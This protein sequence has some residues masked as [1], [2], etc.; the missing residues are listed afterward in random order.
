MSAVAPIEIR[1]DSDPRRQRLGRIVSYASFAAALLSLSMVWNQLQRYPRTDDAYLRANTIGMAPRVFGQIV[2]LPIRDNQFV[3]TGEVLYRI[4]PRPYE[5]AMARAEANLALVDFEVRALQDAVQVAEARVAT[6]KADV[7]KS[8]ADIVR[9]KADVKAAQARADYAADYLGRIKPL[10]EQQF[11]TADRVALA[12]SDLQAARANVA[13]AEAAVANADATLIAAQA[14]VVSAE[15]EVKRSRNALAQV[16]DVNAR[17]AA[18]KV[19]IDEARLNLQYCEVRAPIDGWVTNL[20]TNVGAFVKVGDNLFSIVQNTE[21]WVIANFLETEIEQI[22]VGQE[23]AVYIYAY[24]GHRFKGTVQGIGWALYQANGATQQTLPDVKPTLNWVRLAQR[25]PVRIT[26]EPFDAEHPYRMGGTV[27]A[28]VKTDGRDP[29]LEQL[30][31]IGSPFGK[32]AGPF[33]EAG[34][35]PTLTPTK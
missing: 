30:G 16:G 22:R 6:S 8:Q 21:W 7:T 35:G 33:P 23:V 27:T 11:V 17:V 32:S 25:F 3:K 5:V 1:K 24:P 13:A 4:D 34:S 2:E 10:L 12:E 18:A 9:R 15:A 29:L 20:N 19:E 26:M 28:I 14:A 31:L